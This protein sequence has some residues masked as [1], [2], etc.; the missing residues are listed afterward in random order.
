MGAPQDT[1]TAEVT[2]MFKVSVEMIED[3]TEFTVADFFEHEI[4]DA[5]LPDK[6]LM[7]ALLEEAGLPL[8]ITAT[9]PI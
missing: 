8:K 1:A 9:C 4:K 6:S 5:L 3:C 2:V 7:N